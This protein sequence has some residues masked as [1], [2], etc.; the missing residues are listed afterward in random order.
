M[1]EQLIQIFEDSNYTVKGF[2][3]IL[4]ISRV[5]LYKILNNKSFLTVKKFNI[6]NERLHN[7]Q[8]GLKQKRN[9]IH[10]FTRE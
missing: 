1:N 8:K 4:G 5:T 7:Y 3:E 6:Y 2:A 10:E 9:S